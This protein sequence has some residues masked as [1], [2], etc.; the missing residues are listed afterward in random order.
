MQRPHPAILAKPRLPWTLPAKPA[1]KRTPED[2][3]HDRATMD[4]QAQQRAQTQS[5]R[6]QSQQRQQAEHVQ[7][8]AER[9]SKAQEAAKQTREEAAKAK[10]RRDKAVADR[11]GAPLPVPGAP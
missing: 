4:A 8:E 11:K 2:V 7:A 9:R 1:P 10:A 5:Q 3:A 6:A